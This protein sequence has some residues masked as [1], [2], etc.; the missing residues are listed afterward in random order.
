MRMCISYISPLARQ[1]YLES[2]FW[3]YQV[4]NFILPVCVSGASLVNSQRK[5]QPC[6]ITPVT[7]PS[8]FGGFATR[9]LWSFTT[10]FL[11][12]GQTDI[13]TPT[14]LLYSLWFLA[15]AHDASV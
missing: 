8:P 13:T 7:P 14:S 12:G 5:E 9:G 4:G 15:R 1:E 6:Q 3:D 2:L 10:N 11:H